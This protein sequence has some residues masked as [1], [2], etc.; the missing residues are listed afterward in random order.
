VRE[1]VF[2]R[3][4]GGLRLALGVRQRLL[5]LPARPGV[6]IRFTMEDLGGERGALALV[7]ELEL[8]ALARR[9]AGHW[10]W[11]A[12]R[13]ANPVERVGPFIWRGEN[14]WLRLRATAAADAGGFPIPFADGGARE[15][16]FLLEFLDEEPRADGI[17]EPAE[18]AALAEECER[19]ARRRATWLDEALPHFE[20]D[21]SRLDAWFDASKRSALLTRWEHPDF[22]VDPLFVAAGLD[23]GGVCAYVW[24]LAYVARLL[25][26]LAEP[27]TIRRLLLLYF[28]MGPERHFAFDPFDGSGFGPNY[29]LNAH[30][31]TRMVREYVAATQ[32]F[33]LLQERLAGGGDLLA[34]L[35]SLARSGTPTKLG[36]LFDYGDTTHLLEMRTAGY[37]H[38]VPSPNAERCWILRTL[39]EFHDRAAGGRGDRLR[40]DADAVAAALREHLWDEQAGWLRCLDPDGKHAQLVF[41]VQVLTILG[42]DVLPR[43]LCARLASRVR[44]GEFLGTHGLHSVSLA[45]RLHYEAGD[46][47]WGGGG[48]YVGQGP[49]LVQDLYHVGADAAAETLLERMTWWASLYPYFPQSIRADRASYCDFDRPNCIAGLAGAQAIVA[50]LCGFEPR[51]DGTLAIAPRVFRGSGWRL[52]NLR[53]AGRSVDVEC[54]PARWRARV[55]GADRGERELGTPLILER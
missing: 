21:S 6:L 32:D 46:V 17:L 14:G 23:G 11:F 27:A 8:P 48:S 35:E 31:L 41:S 55:D 3:P 34:R 20:S 9:G 25:P 45:D 12:P 30:A 47:D 37:E 50:G 7:P 39:A 28:N 44:D 43:E 29:A 16:C 15:L 54:G 36:P 22:V 33:T 51:L 40:A 49:L 19:A 5:P 24:D 26:M 38:V 2:H 52:R 53:W 4:L 18:A 42:L 10:T 13:F 1:S